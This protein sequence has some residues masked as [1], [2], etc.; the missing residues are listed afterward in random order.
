VCV[1]RKLGRNFL[2]SKSLMDQP[3]GIYRKLEFEELLAKACERGRVKRGD[4]KAARSSVKC[5]DLE[6]PE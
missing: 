4:E 3:A 6:T 2:G 5:A 1:Y